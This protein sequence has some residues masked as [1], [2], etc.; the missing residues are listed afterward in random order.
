DGAASPILQRCDKRFYVSPFMDMELSYA[1][2]VTPPGE[3]LGVA[4]RAEDRDGLLLATSFSGKRREIG[5]A[6]LLGT[7]I[8]HPFL[9]L[10]VVAGIH[11]EAVWLW[12]KG[13][14]LTPRPPP[15]A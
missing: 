3:A 7:V 12:L 6:S 4:V 13:V 9:T 5:T 14:R 11:W 1:F 8:K 15:P 10:K 2:R